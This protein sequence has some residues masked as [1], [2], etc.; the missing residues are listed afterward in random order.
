MTLLCT[1]SGQYT[2]V[3]GMNVTLVTGASRGIGRA[4][5]RQLTRFGTVLATAR[6]P[7]QAEQPGV[8]TLR[9]DVT[10]EATIRAAVKVVEERYG[11]LDALVNN[12]GISLERGTDPAEVDAGTLRR[13]YETNVIGV[14]AV[15]HAFL[16]LLRRSPA[17]R[18]VNVSG[19]SGSLGEWSDPQSPVA[20]FAPLVLSYNSSK[21][22]LNALTVGYA[23]ALRDMKVNAAS[24][25]YVATDLNGHRGFR[26]V[27]EGAAI[28]VK[29]ATLDADGPTGGFFNDDGPIRW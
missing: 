7:R 21:S 19:A 9:L 8:E 29:L 15:T 4:V 25:G 11:R 12:A 20:Q 13:V 23:R 1:G 18:I 6:D 3:R 14:V 27:E 10:D 16:P 28:I 24:P 26:T 5:A 17:A 2:M 22:A